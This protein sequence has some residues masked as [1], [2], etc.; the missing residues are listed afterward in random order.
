MQGEKNLDVRKTKMS[1]FETAIKLKLNQSKKIYAII[2]SL[3][4]EIYK[5]NYK[6]K[7]ILW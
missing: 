7:F 1:L 5:F 4:D 3:T 2:I 6:L